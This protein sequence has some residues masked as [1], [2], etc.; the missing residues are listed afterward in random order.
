MGFYWIWP[1]GILVGGPGNEGELIQIVCS[2]GHSSA[3]V[4]WVSGTA[5]F[6]L[7]I[8]VLL[9]WFPY[10]S[11]WLVNRPFIKPFPNYHHSCHFFSCCSYNK[12]LVQ[13][14]QVPCLHDKSLQLCLT[15]CNPIN[16]SPPGSS[17]HGILQARILEWVVM[18]FSRTKYHGTVQKSK[19]SSLILLKNTFQGTLLMR[20]KSKWGLV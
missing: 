3:Q 10:T 4:P 8:S 18:P 14:Y 1:K 15:L 11:A 5:I 9:F 16:C 20:K 13:L 17:V 6:P 12:N 7:Q 2:Q 19:Q